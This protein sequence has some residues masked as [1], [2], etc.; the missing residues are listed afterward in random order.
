MTML[1]L[2]QKSL[3]T[4]L[5]LA[6]A[7]MSMPATASAD[8]FT[9]GFGIGDGRYEQRHR[10]RYEQGMGVFG[11]MPIN[12]DSDH[13]RRRERRGGCSQWEAIDTARSYGL[14]R[15][16]IEHYGRNIVVVGRRHGM[17][18]RLIIFNAP[19]CPVG[20]F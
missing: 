4:G 17:S 10:P 20:G 12:P 5:V 9:F 6:S 16:Y 18:D 11:G 13:G 2:I 14:R 19:G 15:P 7:A 1:N 8:S 3:L